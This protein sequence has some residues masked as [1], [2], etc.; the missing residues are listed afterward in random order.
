M[1]S[2]PILEIHVGKLIFSANSVEDSLTPSMMALSG[3]TLFLDWLVNFFT[4]V[5]Q[6]LESVSLFNVSLINWRLLPLILCC[7]R[8]F[9]TLYDLQPFL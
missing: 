4:V 8:A 2:Q 7:T 5:H 3:A 9:K 1:S 6:V